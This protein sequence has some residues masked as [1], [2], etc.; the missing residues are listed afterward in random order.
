MLFK[1]NYTLIFAMVNGSAVTRQEQKKI[2]CKF[3]YIFL[4]NILLVSHLGYAA[5]FPPFFV[6]LFLLFKFGNDAK[7]LYLFNQ[8]VISGDIYCIIY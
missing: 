4:G 3:T 8:C 1:A 6:V 5:P 7:F 2:G